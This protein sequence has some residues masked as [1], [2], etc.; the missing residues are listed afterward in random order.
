MKMLTAIGG[1]LGVIL[2]APS[3]KIAVLD[4]VVDL[5]HASFVG[6]RLVQHRNRILDTE[7]LPASLH[8]THVASLIFGQRNGPVAG[9]APDCSGVSL[10]IFATTPGEG[11]VRACSQL[12]L[13]RAISEA[14]N[15]GAQ[16]INISGGEFTPGGA[17][18]PFLA[19]VVAECAR[20]GVLIVAAVGN[21][22]CAC[23]HVPAA[24]DS[25]LAVGAIDARGEPLPMSNWSGPYQLQ[26]IVAPGLEIEGAAPGG[27]T[28]KLSGTSISA[29]IVSGV[30]ALLLS[31]QIRRGMPADPRA[32]RS[33][34][35]Q[36]ALDCRNQPAWDCQR[37]LVGRLNVPGAIDLLFKDRIAMSDTL[38]PAATHTVSFQPMPAMPAGMTAIEANVSPSACGCGGAPSRIVYA[39]GQLGHDLISEARLDGMAQSMAEESQT[40]EQIRNGTL[41]IDRNAPRDPIR[42]LAHLDKCPSN[43]QAV[44]WLLLLDETPIYAIRPEGPYAA[45]IYAELRTF[46]RD[47]VYNG[48]ERISMAGVI[49]GSTRLLSGQT[50]P[51]VRPEKRGMYNWS[52]RELA[53]YAAGFPA[54]DYSDDDK[55]AAAKIASD[56]AAQA[57]LLTRYSAIVAA[58]P[59]T[60]A[61]KTKAEQT[62]KSSVA[63]AQA[64]QAASDSLNQAPTTANPA[65][66]DPRN[67]FSSSIANFLE[68]IYYGLRNLGVLPQDRA[69]NYA[70]TNAYNFERVYESAFNDNLEL[71]TIQVV[72]SPFCRPGSDCWDVQLYFFRSQDQVQRVRRVYRYTI[73]VSDV[74]PVTVGPTRS[75]NER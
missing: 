54:A 9:L 69:L 22:G 36:S 55:A 7:G 21:E 11:A 10:P 58:G 67:Q 34:L 49:T 61:E 35:L 25:V 31:M 50:V 39:L 27:G 8:G 19:D 13:A 20:R 38:S 24:L 65:P 41:Q 14:V 37:L 18:H 66:N 45:E 17:A 23:L 72:R 51:V 59:A 26:G 52:T 62:A 30:A 6:S 12:D 56:A 46:L 64:L 4:G 5:A 53:Q 57:D 74:V 29:A 73:D 68:K 75:W 43:A 28:A 1:S 44:E 3:V 32:V 33:A 60:A 71:D 40:I 2:G 63:L 42:L 15:D 70:A 47:Q 48:A 16:I